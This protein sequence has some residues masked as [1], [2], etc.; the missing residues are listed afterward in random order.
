M[1]DAAVPF[2]DKDLGAVLRANAVPLPVQRWALGNGCDT[3]KAFANW[4]DK[5]EDLQA[6]ILAEVGG[7]H[8]NS[9]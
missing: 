2:P 6:A 8:T 9:R 3:L 1:G 4:A 7:E 5:R